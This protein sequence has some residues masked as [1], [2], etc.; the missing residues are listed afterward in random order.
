MDKLNGLNQLHLALVYIRRGHYTNGI[1]IRKGS[2]GTYTRRGHTEGTYTRR[3][4][5]HERDI[6]TERI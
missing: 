5:P 4:H 3:G 1:F 6:H 2:T